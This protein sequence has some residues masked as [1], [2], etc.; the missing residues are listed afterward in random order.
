MAA[1]LKSFRERL[2]PS[3][4][5]IQ[6]VSDLHLELG[7]QYSSYVIPPSA[8]FLLLGGDIGRL[9]D[10]DEY[11]K[12]LEVHVRQ[13]DKVFLVLGNH[14]FYGLGY[15]VGL[16]T[17]RRLSEEPS[18]AGKVLLLHRTRWDN[19]NSTLTIL[20][21]TLWSEIPD[22]ACGIVE[23]KVNDFKQ[24]PGWSARKHNMIHAEE[25]DWLRS[26]IGQGV[27]HDGKTKRRILIVTHHAPCVEGTSRPEHVNNPW[28]SAF[29]TDLV[30]QGGWHGVKTWVFGHTHYSVK[31]FRDGIKIVANQRGYVLPGEA[32]Q[33]RSL[34]AGN[35]GRK[36]DPTMV[37]KV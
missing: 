36:F 13:Y 23:S 9:V 4:P 30:V 20:G 29:A 24:I 3:N 37:V 6:I 34:E 31:L 35:N 21:C 1:F 18:L 22:R 32:G 25:V 11:L 33:E 28:S 27:P 16:D 7:Q 12:F 2:H 15:E 19:P 5:R 17:A 26:Q 10:Y 14:E 8:P